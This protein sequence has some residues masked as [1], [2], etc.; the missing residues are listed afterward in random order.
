MSSLGS[1][2][3]KRFEL[4]TN[5]HWTGRSWINGKPIFRKVV[6][7]GAFPDMST[8]TVAHG[9]TD[10]DEWID[11]RVVGINSTKEN[12]TFT[13]GLTAVNV[14]VTTP[15]AMSTFSGYA[16]LEYTKT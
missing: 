10:I 15:I 14:E 5:E 3:G 12:P 8:K 11:Y 13:L 9:I 2:D 16:I 6:D 1:R 4:S 7:I